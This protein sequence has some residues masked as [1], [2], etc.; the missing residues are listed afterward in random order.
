MAL[1]DG[2]DVSMVSQQAEHTIAIHMVTPEAVEKFFWS[3]VT[4]EM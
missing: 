2:Q 4:N 1:L 3:H